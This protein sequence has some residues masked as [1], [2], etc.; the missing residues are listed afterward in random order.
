MFGGEESDDECIL[1]A[2][3]VTPKP[4]RHSLLFSTNSKQEAGYQPTM[5]DGEYDN[6]D[7]PSMMLKEILLTADTSHFDLL[8]MS[9]LF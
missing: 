6:N 7:L 3:D 5:E 2:I 9:L 4:P 1:K 8:G